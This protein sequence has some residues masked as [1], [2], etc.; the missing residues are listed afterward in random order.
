M[1]GFRHRFYLANHHLATDFTN[2]LRI[3]GVEFLSNSKAL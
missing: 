2:T 1:L 3:V